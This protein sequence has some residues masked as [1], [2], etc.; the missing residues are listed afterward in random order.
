MIQIGQRLYEERLRRGL[1]I[2]EVANAT[3]IRPQ[4]IKAIETGNY[5]QLPSSAYALGFVKN[6]VSFLGLPTR[7]FLPLFRREF[8]EKEYNDVLPESFTRPKTR[9]LKQ[10][11]IGRIII[12]I[13][14]ILIPLLGYVFFQYRFAFFNPGLRIQ[15]PI[16]NAKVTSDVV[17]VTGKTD[18]NVLITINGTSVLVDNNGYFTKDVMVFPGPMTITVTAVNSFGRKMTVQRHIV[19]Q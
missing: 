8:D 6:Y 18:Q 13:L 9:S 2:D 15:N 19:I 14:V 1:T 10:A 16:E 12:V 3:K 7:Q 17:S 5:K 4:F 11:R